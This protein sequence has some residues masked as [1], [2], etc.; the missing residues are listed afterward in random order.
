MEVNVVR[1]RVESLIDADEIFLTNV[2][3]GALFVDNLSFC[4][5]GFSKDFYNKVNQIIKNIR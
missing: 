3:V 2:R 1:S 5:N 4:D